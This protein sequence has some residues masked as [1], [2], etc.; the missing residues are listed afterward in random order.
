MQS[1]SKSLSPN[2]LTWCGYWFNAEILEVT[3]LS[4][5]PRC[6]NFS[7]EGTNPKSQSWGWL[8]PG[9][10]QSGHFQFQPFPKGVTLRQQWG[11]GKEVEIEMSD[12]NNWKNKI[13]SP[14]FNRFFTIS[15]T[16]WEVLAFEEGGFWCLSSPSDLWVTSS[17]P[18]AELG[19]VPAIPTG[20][21]HIPLW[22]Y[23]G[24][25]GFHWLCV[26]VQTENYHPLA[27]RTSEDRKPGWMVKAKAEG[28]MYF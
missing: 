5:S 13:S 23:L 19:Q 12:K 3:H 14:H 6:L 20:P 25:W 26:L 28:P 10:K 2:T 17:V 9:R 15:I 18:R 16:V 7:E 4:K 22:L 21:I 8:G 27:L 11:G 1:K 24:I